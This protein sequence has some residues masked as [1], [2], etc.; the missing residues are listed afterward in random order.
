MYYIETALNA[1]L[2][3]K[4]VTKRRHGGARSHKRAETNGLL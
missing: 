2:G 1:P 4:Q 3:S